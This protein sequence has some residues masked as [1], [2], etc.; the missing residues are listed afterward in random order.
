LCA[1]ERV[2]KSTTVRKNF[3]VDRTLGNWLP[4]V[5]SKLITLR[6]VNW[7][8]DFVALRKKA[9]APDR[10]LPYSAASNRSAYS[11]TTVAIANGQ[12]LN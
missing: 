4:H 7:L 6:E 11:E 3:V 9:A 12:Q 1:N 10:S 5:W 2:Y 8:L